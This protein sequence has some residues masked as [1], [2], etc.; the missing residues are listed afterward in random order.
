MSGNPERLAANVGLSFQ[1]SIVLGLGFTIQPDRALELIAGDQRN[2]EVLFPY[3]N[4]Q[5]LNSRPDCSAS[6]WVINFHDWP[7]ERAKT[8]PEL[9]AQVLREVKPERERVSFSKHAR[10]RWWQ[11]ERRRPELYDAIAGLQRVIVIAQSSTTQKPVIIPTGQVFDQ[12]L[13]VF[14]SD[15][16]A[17]L[18]LLSSNVHYWW[19][20]SRG[21]TLKRDLVYT[22]SDV[23][24]TFPR[25]EIT[26]EM[27]ELG[28]RLDTFRR[29]V[30]LARQAG[31]TATYNLVHD[32]GCAAADIARL[33]EIHREI[34]EAV[35]RAYGWDDLLISGLD[36]GFH[37]TRQGPRYTIG[38]AVRQEVLDRLLELNQERYAA[39][40]AAGLH[41]GRG[42]RRA[43]RDDG[44]APLF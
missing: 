39:E 23:F 4:G 17:L 28:G 9:H 19:T 1:G 35:V 26:T 37:E 33:R 22:P 8:Y 14:A 13:V 42:R 16:S 5:D 34:D 41:T 25:S 32:Q 20:A 40:V 6:R 7:E 15:D 36:H 38:A 30:M 11:Y 18:T 44:A 43:V 3:L 24:E 27:R 2:A 12:K 21:S 29:E 31:L 10:E